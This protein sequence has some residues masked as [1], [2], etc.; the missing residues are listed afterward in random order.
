MADDNDDYEIGAL[1][2]AP[3][4]AV[5]QAQIEAERE[6]VE[7]LF[8]YGMEETTRKVG[9]KTVKGLKLSEFEFGMTRSIDDPTRPG[10]SIDHE[11]RVR[12]PLLSIIQMPAVGIEEATID[13]DLDVEYDREETQ[14]AGGNATTGSRSGVLPKKSIRTPVLKGSIGNRTV[15][16][17]FRTQGKLA[18]S[19]KLRSTHDDDMHGRLSRLIGEG[20]SA[21]V[22]VPDQKEEG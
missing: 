5:Q 16:R 13:L 3:V 21:A 17:N 22:D 11:A 20:L 15:S 18:V 12:A 1:L 2:G 7:F 4:R 9:N 10:V 14:K 19:L 6:F 8:D